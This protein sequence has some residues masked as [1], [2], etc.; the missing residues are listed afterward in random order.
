M[1]KK[2]VK[3]IIDEKKT[4]KKKYQNER[5]KNIFWKRNRLMEKYWTS[6]DGQGTKN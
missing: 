3:V 4:S 1:E 5:E 6:S 2:S